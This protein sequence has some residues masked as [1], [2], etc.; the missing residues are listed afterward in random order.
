MEG[1][2]DVTFAGD[3]PGGRAAKPDSSDLNDASAAG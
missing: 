2:R 1:K 3:S